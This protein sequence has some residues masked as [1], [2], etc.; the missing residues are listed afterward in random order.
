MWSRSGGSVYTFGSSTGRLPGS[1]ANT[2]VCLPDFHLNPSQKGL[3][4][5]IQC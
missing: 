1:E 3:Q 5:N 2:F 4:A